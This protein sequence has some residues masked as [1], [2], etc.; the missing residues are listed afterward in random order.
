MPPQMVVQQRKDGTLRG[1]DAAVDQKLEKGQ[2]DQQRGPGHG[3][4]GLCALHADRKDHAV[5]RENDNAAQQRCPEYRRKVPPRQKQKHPHQTPAHIA[6]TLF[7]RLP[8]TFALQ[9]KQRQHQHPG[10]TQQQ[11]QNTGCGIKRVIPRVCPDDA[12]NVLR[13]GQL[14]DIV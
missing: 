8:E 10:E 13:N 14:G 9:H 7:D 2:L 11:D 1:G 3:E 6:D 5:Q 4:H 12:Q